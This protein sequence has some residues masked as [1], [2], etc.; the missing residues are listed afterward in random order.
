MTEEEL[1]AAFDDLNKEPSQNSLVCLE[2]GSV[3]KK[4]TPP[5]EPLS[6]GLDSFSHQQL[7]AN[8]LENGTESHANET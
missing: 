3:T 2:H 4:E 6:S 5:K 1:T 7:D 8:S